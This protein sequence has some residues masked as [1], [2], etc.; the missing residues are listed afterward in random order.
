M[1]AYEVSL[2][3]EG[4]RVAVAW[5]GGVEG[6]D[7]IW[8][9]TLGPRGR[10][11]TGPVRVSDELRDAYE[12]DLQWLDGDL[13]V[14]W[15]EKE[16]NGSL[17]AWV[18]RF[19]VDGRERWRIA[20]AAADRRSRNP[21]VRV[22]GG[23][24]YVAWLESNGEDDP[25]VRVTVLDVEGQV[26]RDAIRLGPASRETWNLNAALDGN[27]GF[28]VVYDARRGSRAKEIHLARLLPD[29][30]VATER[31]GDDD[32]H[33]S[34]YP[35]IAIDGDTLALTWFDS[36]DGNEE[37]YLAVGTDA[38]LAAALPDRSRR[39]T[40]TPGPSIGAYLAWNGQRLLV[41]WSD[42][43]A[44]QKEV[45]RQEFDRQGDVAGPPVRMTKTATDS[46]IPA[47]RPAGTGFWVAW[48]ERRA[49]PADR[50]LA[51]GP[52]ASSRVRIERVQ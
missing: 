9:E 18:G 23:R 38:Q 29:G 46:L 51:H 12:P 39:I 35:D 4:E 2:A 30:T 14:A 48:T 37:V 26:I 5:H 20:L 42:E 52:T 36:R 40:R 49:L 24:A 11:A 22:S 44:G 25:D 13:V 45:F 7:G 17:R 6:R 41:A 8:I 34:V 27:G 50:G 10:I 33:D 32:G 16:R 1:L 3:V 19:A 43:L 15:Y 47:V 31:L 21:V 28:D